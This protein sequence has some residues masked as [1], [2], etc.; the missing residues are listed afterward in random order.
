MSFSACLSLSFSFALLLLF[1]SFPF[2]SVCNSKRSFSFHGSLFVSS[3]FNLFSFL[4][5]LNSLLFLSSSFFSPAHTLTNIEICLL[6]LI[7]TCCPFSHNLWLF[8]SRKWN[9]F[10][11]FSVSVFLRSLACGQH[12]ITHLYSSIFTSISLFRDCC[13]VLIQSLSSLPIY[14][15]STFWLLPNLLITVTDAKLQISVTLAGNWRS[16]LPIIQGERW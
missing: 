10:T 4:S 9:L 12:S 15:L 8:Y 6:V 16:S 3:S 13:E 14:L 5:V 2:F 11:F 1:L 7:C